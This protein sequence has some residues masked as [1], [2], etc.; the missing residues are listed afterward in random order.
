ML[1]M[2]S[3]HVR[4]GH[5]LRMLMLPQVI[6]LREQQREQAQATEVQAQAAAT[7]ASATIAALQQQLQKAQATGA[8]TCEELTRFKGHAAAFCGAVLGPAHVASLT[9]RDNSNAAGGQ[10][11]SGKRGKVGEADAAQQGS[12]KRR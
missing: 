10:R 12:A 8:A 2:P 3:R 11:L 9:A 1:G 5:S 6:Y 4:A 7:Q